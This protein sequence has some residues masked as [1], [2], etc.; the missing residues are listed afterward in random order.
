M[1]T[2]QKQL[3]EL[4]AADV[5]ELSKQAKEGIC[6]ETDNIL[7]THIKLYKIIKEGEFASNDIVFINQTEKEIV[8]PIYIDPINTSKDNVEL[9]TE[10]FDYAR[11][12]EQGKIYKKFFNDLKNDNTI[13]DNL[14]IKWLED[15]S[16]PS[17]K[18]SIPNADDKCRLLLKSWDNVQNLSEKQLDVIKTEVV[19]SEEKNDELLLEGFSHIQ[20]LIKSFNKKANKNNR[21]ALE[22]A[23]EILEIKDTLELTRD[24]KRNIDSDITRIK[25]F[26]ADKT[27]IEIEGPSYTSQIIENQLPK[28]TPKKV[29]GTFVLKTIGGVV[30]DIFIHENV[31]RKLRLATGD[32]VSLVEIEDCKKDF[33]FDVTIKTKKSKN[34]DDNIESFE[35]AIVER[36]EGALV[37]TK[38]ASGQTLAEYCGIENFVYKISKT[39]ELLLGLSEGDVVNI[40]WYKDDFPG[41]IQIAWKYPTEQVVKPT[42]E[43]KVLANT[44]V[45]EVDEDQE[46]TSNS[47]S[48]DLEGKS[49]LV[50]GYERKHADWKAFIEAN[51]GVFD[52]YIKNGPKRSE[53]KHR[54]AKADIVVIAENLVNH[55]TYYVGKALCKDLD[56]PLISF[57]GQGNNGLIKALESYY[58]GESEDQSMD[59]KYLVNDENSLK[60]SILAF[61]EMERKRQKDILAIQ[62]ALA[63]VDGFERISLSNSAAKKYKK[64]IKRVNAF[65]K[66]LD[67]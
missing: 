32:W 14:F 52:A 53:L 19:V 34:I 49:V 8:T 42:I 10:L 33:K 45:K 39:D 23:L 1:N 17:T 63:I 35:D 59:F 3:L 47:H 44:D 26:V 22:Y 62:M 66:A 7:Q 48:F 29:E 27:T 38:R 60:T 13:L 31:V 6:K 18:N 50:L 58:M 37:I 67:N 20:R 2:I 30:D 46:D 21:L 4:V 41:S 5:A 43:K 56:T 51:N 16:F 28:F 65:L 64:P 55:A 11:G 9:S 36:L 25:R 54:V 57:K 12:F 15:N 40:R 24:Q 61:E